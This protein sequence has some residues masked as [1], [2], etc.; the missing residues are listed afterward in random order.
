MFSQQRLTMVPPDI[1]KVAV[2]TAGPMKLGQSLPWNAQNIQNHRASVVTR[3][4]KDRALALGRGAPSKNSRQ[5]P[6]PAIDMCRHQV[7]PATHLGRKMGRAQSASTL[8]GTHDYISGQTSARCKW[9]VLHCSRWRSWGY[10]SRVTAGETGDS[11]TDWKGKQSSVW[12]LWLCGDKTGGFKHCKA[13]SFLS[14][15][16]FQSLPMVMNLWDW[17][18][19]FYLKWQGWDFCEKFTVWHFATK[20][21]AVKFAEPW[22][23]IHFCE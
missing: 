13:V 8:H 2:Q 16:L 7:A 6:P 12:A 18:E 20:C 15:F 19:E 14:R 4:I 22:M 5:S 9:T 1:A 11:W 21:A 23:S 10:Y 17:L 3:V